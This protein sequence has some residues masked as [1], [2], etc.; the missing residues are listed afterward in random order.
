MTACMGCLT[1]G[2]SIADATLASPQR[3]AAWRVGAGTKFQSQTR[4]L[5]PR[6]ISKLDIAGGSDHVSIADATLASP[7][8][9]KRNGN[10]SSPRMFQSQ[11]R[12]LPPRNVEYALKTRESQCVS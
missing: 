7:Q 5:P 1:L 4:R 11:T 2:V 6:N 12:R 3:K 8:Q 10:Y 9:R